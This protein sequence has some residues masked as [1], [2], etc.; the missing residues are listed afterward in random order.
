[1]FD[2]IQ[3]GIP[4]KKS[5]FKL[6]NPKNA[7]SVDL[8]AEAVIVGVGFSVVAIVAGLPGLDTA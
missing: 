8:V 4:E 5:P 6:P 7:G 1:M 2:D 3:T